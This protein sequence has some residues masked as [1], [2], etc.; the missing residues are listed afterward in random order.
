MY[1][2]RNIITHEYF[3]IDYEVIWEIAKNELP[4]NRLDLLKLIEKENI[5]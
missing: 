2:L 4:K 1:G 3:G 5:Q